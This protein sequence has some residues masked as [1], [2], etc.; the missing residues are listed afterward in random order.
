LPSPAIRRPSCVRPSVIR[1]ELSHVK[2]LNRIK[3]NLVG[4][5]LGWVP[6]KIVSDSPTLHS[7]WLLLLK[8]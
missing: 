4:M 6:F 1:R 7:R 3:P 8:I 2:P 5:V